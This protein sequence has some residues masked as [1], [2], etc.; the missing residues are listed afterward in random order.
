MGTV[1]PFKKEFSWPELIDTE[2]GIKQI[3]HSLVEGQACRA[4]QV[5]GYGHLSKHHV[6]AMEEWLESDEAQLFPNGYLAKAVKEWIHLC[7]LDLKDQE[8]ER[9]DQPK[10]ED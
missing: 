3:L 2:N 5:A 9:A 1:T 10:Q 6:D 8:R 7:R 4:F